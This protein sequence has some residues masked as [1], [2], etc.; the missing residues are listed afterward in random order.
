MRMCVFDLNVILFAFMY[1]NRQKLQKH[2]QFMQ[3]QLE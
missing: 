1:M 3:Y 2:S